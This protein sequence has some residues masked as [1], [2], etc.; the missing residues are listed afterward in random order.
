MR[1]EF[2][3]VAATSR[4]M[5]VGLPSLAIPCDS[6]PTNQH[7]IDTLG[8]QSPDELLVGV[9][10]SQVVVEPVHHGILTRVLAATI[11]RS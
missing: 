11:T 3:G 8:D 1:S 7:E 9:P 5:I 6:E 2:S 4:S 10:M